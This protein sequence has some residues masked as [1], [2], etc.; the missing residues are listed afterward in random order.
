M[1]MTKVI[2]AFHDYASAP[3]KVARLFSVKP[4]TCDRG[5]ILG[6]MMMINMT[7]LL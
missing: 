5:L 3:K 4:V 6:S 7:A 2:G 1:D